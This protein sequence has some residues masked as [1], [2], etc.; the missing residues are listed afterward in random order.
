MS[1]GGGRIGTHSCILSNG[2]LD[3]LKPISGDFDAST[4][5][6]PRLNDAESCTRGQK[7]TDR[8]RTSHLVSFA[9]LL[10]AD[11]RCP[12]IDVCASP[13]ITTDVLTRTR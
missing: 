10:D 11:M 9:R 12:R 1:S 4:F 5:G 8:P 13:R 2:A 6:G 3:V 7:R